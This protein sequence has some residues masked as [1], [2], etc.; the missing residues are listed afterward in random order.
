MCRSEQLSSPSGDAKCPPGM[1]QSRSYPSCCNVSCPADCGPVLSGA[2]LHCCHFFRRGV[3]PVLILTWER[4][5][6]SGSLAVKSS[7][8]CSS[9]NP[10]DNLC[11]RGSFIAFDPSANHLCYHLPIFH[12]GF[13]LLLID[14]KECLVHSLC[15]SLT[16]FRSCRHLVLVCLA[17]L[18]FVAA[19]PQ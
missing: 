18:N 10:S 16:S 17:Q 6:G 3:N 14:R 7:L 11:V 1:P 13:C 9:L 5:G 2:H 15:E 8:C 4:N 12:W 19:L